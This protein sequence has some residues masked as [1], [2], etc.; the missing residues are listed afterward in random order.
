MSYF[1][2][3]VLPGNV[4]CADPGDKDVGGVLLEDDLVVRGQGEEGGLVGVA[5]PEA[6][7][8]REDWKKWEKMDG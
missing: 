7:R 4:L 3:E 1:E 5:A 2:D 8:G 6:G